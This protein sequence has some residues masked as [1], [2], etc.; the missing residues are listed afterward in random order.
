MGKDYYQILGVS[1]SASQD[2]IKRAYKRMALKWHPDRN[3]DNKDQATEMFK[4]IGEAYDVLSDPE[5]KK[6]YDQF[7][8]EGLKGM[9]DDSDATSSDPFTSSSSGPRIFFTSSGSGSKKYGFRDPF[10]LFSQF[11]P[12]FDTFD[13]GGDHGFFHFSTTPPSHASFSS[14]PSSSYASS[15]SSSSSSFSSA[16]GSSS[17]SSSSFRNSPPPSHRTTPI[18]DPPII[19]DVYLSLEDLYKGTTKKMKIS[20]TVE[21]KDGSK[22]VEEKILELPIR[23]GMKEGTKIT[24]EKA[25]DQKPQHI[26]SD[27]VFII[28]QKKH[29]EYEREG[30][31]LILHKSISLEEALCGVE[32]D[33]KH[34]DGSIIHLSSSNI[35]TPAPLPSSLSPSSFSLSS[36]PPSSFIRVPN[37]GMPLSRS[38]SFGDLIVVFSVSFPSSLSPQ[39]KNLIHQ[40]LGKK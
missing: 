16:G 22:K 1:R 9:S 19:H 26:P 13:M 36:L 3:R 39:Q 17:F 24:F 11:F 7:G 25:G 32:M 28:H 10:S 6:V 23:P 18:A 27:V 5:K 30:N 40:A 8:E 21:E 34:I 14:S 38:S 37:R 31:D 12:D 20:R 33:I 15:S 4:Q 29:E 2:D 35:I